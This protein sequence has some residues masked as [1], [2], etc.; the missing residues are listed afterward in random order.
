MPLQ[1]RRGLQAERQAMT[2]PLASGELLYVI[3]DEQLYIGNGTT[4]GGLQV[5]GYNDEQARDAAASLFTTATH[6]NVEFTYNDNSNTLSA[7]VDL[8][9]Y[10]GTIKASSFNGSVVADDSSLLV[11]ATNGSFNLNGTIKGNVIPDI[12]ATRDL[13]EPSVRFK[14]LYLS[15]SV[16]AGNLIG[17][18]TGSVFGDDSTLLVDATES[19]LNTSGLIIQS[20]IISAPSSRVILEGN[21]ELTSQVSVNI[22]S[23][24]NPTDGIV[25]GLGLSGNIELFV[26]NKDIS[27]NSINFVGGEITGSILFNPFQSDNDLDFPNA[28]GFQADPAGTTSGAHIPGKFFVVTQP[29]IGG[30]GFKFMTFDSFGRLAVNQETAQ[31]TVDINGFM[32]LAI[33]TAEPATPANGMVAIADGTT[34]NPLSNGKQ[35]MVVYLG[36]GWREIAA[37]P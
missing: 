15:G 12:T 27:N 17:D 24:D 1:I 23:S 29:N 20:N 32:K 34:W 21:G 6:T 31:A 25:A 28:L 36:G 18:I 16:Y 9:N 7:E 11:D 2:V 8:S 13:G 22:N 30:G 37:A 4:L 3:D 26:L 19:S 5:T 10:L 14:D 33:L 35:S